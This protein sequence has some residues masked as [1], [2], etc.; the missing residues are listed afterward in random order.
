MQLIGTTEIHLK[1]AGKSAL[2]FA[3]ENQATETIEILMK[4]EA[5]SK[6]QYSRFNKKGRG[7]P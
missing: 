3:L 4:L 5:P 1:P 6:E 2:D 7:T